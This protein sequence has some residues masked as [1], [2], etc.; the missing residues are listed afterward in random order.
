MSIIKLKR[1]IRE[2]VRKALKEGTKPTG[3]ITEEEFL[4]WLKSLNPKAVE[5][6]QD[7]DTSDID[8]SDLV[9][10]YTDILSKYKIP[11][12]IVNIKHDNYGG[13]KSITL[14]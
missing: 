7:I 14:K 6:I 8:T 3:N 11:A 4:Y 2:E 9:N 13:I 10:S 1:L 5:E 12:T